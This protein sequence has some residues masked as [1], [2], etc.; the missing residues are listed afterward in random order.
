MPSH[1]SQVPEDR[2][3]SSSERGLI[4]WLLEHAR[5]GASQFIPQ[6]E[7]LRVMSHCACGCASIN[8]V[9]FELSAAVEIL[10]DYKWQD[11]A[12]PRFGIMLFQKAGVLAGLEVYSIDG[13]GIPMALPNVAWLIPV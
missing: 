5:P 11:D 10:A 9:G 8:F 12:G 1:S 13:E 2:A 7:A 4:K 6:L 3:P